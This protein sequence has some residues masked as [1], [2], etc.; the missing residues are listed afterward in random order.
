MRGALSFFHC[1]NPYQ[2]ICLA[3][4]VWYG[5]FGT[6]DPFFLNQSKYFFLLVKL[7]H[8]SDI[9]VLCHVTYKNGKMKMRLF[10]R[11]SDLCAERS[12]NNFPSPF[13]SWDAFRS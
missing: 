8:F 7:K 12:S 3:S 1:V 4:T 5:T 10:Y 6:Y 9:F 11:I 2:Y 13:A